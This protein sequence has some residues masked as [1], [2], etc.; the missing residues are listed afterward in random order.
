M[1]ELVET[2]GQQAVIKVIGIG[3]GGGNAVDHMLSANLDGVEFINANT[4]AQALDM[5]PVPNKVALG[6]KGLGAGSVPMIA[7][8]AADMIRGRDA[9]KP[10]EE[11]VSA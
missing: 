5:S 7:E 8:K 6:E 1:F 9:L 4:D 3:G 2:V 11:L 10:A